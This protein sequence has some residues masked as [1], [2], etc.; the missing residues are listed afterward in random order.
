MFN[1]ILG[2]LFDVKRHTGGTS[3]DMVHRCLGQ[4]IAPCSSIR[5]ARHQFNQARDRQIRQ[6]PEVQG[7][8]MAAM[9]Q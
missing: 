7:E 1:G 3:R 2:D 6:P 5:Q 4:D 9:I 8:G